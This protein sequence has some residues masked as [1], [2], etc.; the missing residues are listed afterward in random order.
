MK[1]WKEIPIPNNM[2]ELDTDK[3]GYPVPF[4]IMK[5][6]EGKPHFTIN[7]ERLVHKCIEE[8][9]CSI[10]GKKLENDMWLI[11]GP[12]STFHPHGAFNDSPVHY[13]CGKY[14][15]QVCPYLA[16]SVYNAKTDVERIKKEKFDNFEFVNP[17]Q[18][19]D[20]VP[21]FCFIKIRGFRLRVYSPA[22]R[23]IIPDKPYL[24]IEF[25]NNGEQISEED[26]LRLSGITKK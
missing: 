16:V 11:G 21:F 14:A 1:N 5:D 24:Q 15:L 13:E 25:W 20:K 3:R 9:L 23:Y 2:K 7:D 18:G 4:I 8:E 26:A 10:C 12:M 19:N 22:E 17:T 6:K